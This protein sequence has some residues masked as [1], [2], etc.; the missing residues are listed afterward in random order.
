MTFVVL[1]DLW[2]RCSLLVLVHMSFGDALDKL[3]VDFVSHFN[4]IQEIGGAFTHITHIPN[5]LVSVFVLQNVSHLILAQLYLI[6]R[7]QCLNR[8]LMDPLLFKYVGQLET[9]FHRTD[10]FELSCNCVFVRKTVNVVASFLLV[11]GSNYLGTAFDLV[12][13]GL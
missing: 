3:R 1:A 4:L 5:T 10:A 8:G 12:L 11:C 13:G 2:T 9:I 7:Q 6:L